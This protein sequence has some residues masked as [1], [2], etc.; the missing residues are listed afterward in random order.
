MSN[1]IAFT[2]DE[3]NP[4]SA[5]II[6]SGNSDSA[7]VYFKNKNDSDPDGGL[8]LQIAD[9]TS[10]PFIF[11]EFKNWSADEP[12]VFMKFGYGYGINVINAHYRQNN[13]LGQINAV[14]SSSPSATN[15]TWCW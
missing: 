4:T 10:N 9:D 6:F 2:V 12:E 1:N 14:Q 5:G 13:I 8:Y 11:F 15:M 3:S 7:R